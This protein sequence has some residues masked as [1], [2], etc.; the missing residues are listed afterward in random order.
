MNTLSVSP[1]VNT[2]LS[3]ITAQDEARFEALFKSAAGNAKHISGQI[4]R[5]LLLRS[6]L[7]GDILERIWNLSDFYGLGNLN[8]AQFALAMYLVNLKLEGKDLPPSIPRRIR[9]EVLSWHD[10]Y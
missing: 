1:S 10:W 5:D 6:K 2:G 4:A 3:F 9:D 8:F 7:S